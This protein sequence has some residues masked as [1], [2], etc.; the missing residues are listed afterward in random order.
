MRD[1]QTRVVTHT[2][3]QDATTADKGKS[4]L[5]KCGTY[6]VYGIRDSLHSSSTQIMGSN[7]STT[8]NQQPFV[9]TKIKVEPSCETIHILSDDSNSDTRCLPQ[10]H[11]SVFIPSF[12]NLDSPLSLEDSEPNF[13]L[14]LFD[15]H[16]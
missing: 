2:I 15:Y 6:R 10:L 11:N 3:G 5:L 16:T 9:P 14:Y 1:L 12:D 8:S 4:W 13:I 7:V